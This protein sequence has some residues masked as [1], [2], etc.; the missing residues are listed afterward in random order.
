MYHSGAFHVQVTENL[1]HTGLNTNEIDWLR[2][3]MSRSNSFRLSWIQSHRY[4]HQD[5]I[6]LTIFSPFPLGCSHVFT[7]LSHTG[8]NM[9]VQ[10]NMQTSSQIAQTQVLERSPALIGQ[11]CGCAHPSLHSSGWQPGPMHCPCPQLGME[12]AP[13]E[14]HQWKVGKGSSPKQKQKRRLG[15]KSRLNSGQ[16]QQTPH[17]ILT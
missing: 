10:G 17:P 3:V 5:P 4:C 1:A 6:S 12:S 7:G 2:S 15:P 9:P 11:I 8:A 13:L 16:T 14:H